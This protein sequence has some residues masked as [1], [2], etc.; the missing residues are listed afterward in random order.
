[1]L[2]LGLLFFETKTVQRFYLAQKAY[3]TMG[4]YGRIWREEYQQLTV[5]N[6]RLTPTSLLKLQISREGFS[7][8]RKRTSTKTKNSERISL[9][10]VPKLVAVFFAFRSWTGIVKPNTG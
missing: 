8:L 2:Q 7:I 10:A 6:I 3:R 5:Q 1:M 4:V 9:S